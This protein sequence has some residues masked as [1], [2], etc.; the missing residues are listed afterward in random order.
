MTVNPAANIPSQSTST[1]TTAPFTYSPTGT[2][3]PSGTTYAWAAPTGANFTGGASGAALNA[4][5]TG[6]LTNTTAAAATAIYSVTPTTAGSTNC[7]GT[8]FTVSVVVNPVATILSQPDGTAIC[9][10]VA[11]SYTPTGTIPTTPTTTYAWSAP[12][13]ASG[14]SGGASGT[15]QSQLNGTLF[16]NST[17]SVAATA[18]Y[19]VTPT[20]GICTTG[21]VF[22]VTV[23]INPV[24]NIA[25][26]TTSKCTN[27]PFTYTPTG[28]IPASTTYAWAAPSVQAG[29]TGGVSGAAG[30]TT[31]TATLTNTTAGNL[32]AQYSVTPTSPGSCT[33]GAVFTVTVTV[34]PGTAPTIT[35]PTAI[36]VYGSPSNSTNGSVTG[37]YGAETFGAGSGSGSCGSTVAVDFNVGSVSAGNLKLWCRGDAGV[38][39]DG[40]SKVQAW[41]DV[42]GNGNNF[43]QPTAGSRPSYTASDAS[44][45]GNPAITIGTA[46][47]FL[48]NP[49]TLGNGTVTF[50]MF[51]VDRMNAGT[52]QRLVSSYNTNW[53][54]GNWGTYEDQFYFNSW[55]YGSGGTCGGTVTNTTPD[56]YPHLY[57]AT[58]NGV[59]ASGTNVY[60]MGRLLATCTA[61]T[62]NGPQQIQLGGYNSASTGSE[63]ST[64]EVAEIIYFNSILTTAQRQV[65]EGYL[66][67]KYNLPVPIASMQAFQ[68]YVVGSTNVSFNAADQQGNSTSANSTATVTQY[69]GPD[70][71]NVVNPTTCP[72][73][74][75][76]TLSIANM[77]APAGN[78]L[79]EGVSSSNMLSVSTLQSSTLPT[80]GTTSS[81][82][83]LGSNWTIETWV[84]FPLPANGAGGWNTLC[85][86]VGNHPIICQ[87]VNNTNA[88]NS[89]VILGCFN[90]GFYPASNVGA[91]NAYSIG[92]ASASIYSGVDLSNLTAGWH[93]VAAVGTGGIEKFY[94]DGIFV[95]K[96]TGGQV[97]DNLVAIGNYQGGGQDGGTLDEFKVY[98]TALSQQ[99]ISNYMT[100]PSMPLT[101]SNPDPN[102]NNLVAYYKMAANP[103]VNSAATILPASTAACTGCNG[104]LTGTA[105]LTATN[106][107]TYTWSGPNSPTFSPSSSST[108]ETVTITNP[109]TV[110]SGTYSVVAS[111]N[112]CSSQAT[113]VS[114]TVYPISVLT[115]VQGT[116]TC[117]NVAFSYTPTGTVIS[118]TTYAWSVPTGTGIGNGASG[119]GASIITGNLSSSLS[120]AATAT[121]LVTPTSPSGGT[122]T[123]CTDVV[124]TVTVVV[125]PAAIISSQAASPA[126]CS[127]VAFSYTPTGTIATGTTYSWSVPTQV[128]ITG[129][130][131]GAAGQTQLFGTLTNT[132]TAVQ[133]ATYSITPSSAGC[134]GTV[135]TESV[136]VNPAGIIPD[137][138]TTNCSN[139]TFS[140]T[141]TGTISAGTTYS[142]GIPTQASGLSGGSARVNQSTVNGNLVNNTNGTLTAVYSVTPVATASPGAC[143]G[144]TFNFTVSVSPTPITFGQST[145]T[146]S[147]STFSY[148]PSG[149]FIPNNTV[150]AWSSPSLQSGLSGGASGTGQATVNGTLTN[151]TTSALT[152]QYTVT[153]TAGSCT[154]FTF[155]VTVTVNPSQLVTLTSAAGTDNQATFCQG[156]PLPINIVY[157]MSGSAT[158]VTISGLPTGI[159]YTTSGSVVTISGTPSQAGTFNYTV[160]THGTCNPGTASGVITVG[161]A[162]SISN[163]SDTVC[164]DVAFSYTPTGSIPS[165][166]TYS[167][168]SPIM[169]AG[170]GGGTSGTSQST[171]HG[172]LTNTSAIPATAVYTVTFSST[173]TGASTTFVLFV[174]VN[175]DAVIPSQGTSSCTTIPFSYT[176]TGIVPTGTTYAWSAPSMQSGV[177]G[178]VSGAAGQT[179]LFGTLTNTTSAPATATYSV[180]PV[181]PPG[182]CTGAIFTVTVTVNPV[183]VISSQATSTC[184]G[185][186]FSYPPVGAIPVGTTYAWAAPSGVGV[187]GGGSGAGLSSLL[188]TLNN[189][190]SIPLSVTYSVTPTS[191]T[192]TT[193]APF[194]VTMT[195]NPKPTISSQTGTTC[196]AITFSYTPTGGTIPV[197]TTYQWGAPT[198]A[199]GVTG[200]SAG[201]PASTVTDVLSNTTASPLTATYVVTP[202]SSYGCTGAAFT[203]TMTVN[204]VPLT[205]RVDSTV[206]ACNGGYQSTITITGGTS[207][208]SFNITCTGNGGYSNNYTG[209]VPVSFDI[210]SSTTCTIGTVMDANTCPPISVSPTVA[211]YPDRALTTG[212]T[213]T[214]TVLSLQTKDFFDANA[215]L[216]ATITA[217]ATSLG[218]TTVVAMVDANSATDTT[219]THA[220]LPYYPDS[221]IHS[222][223]YLRRHF[224]ITPATQAPADI[225]LYISQAEVNDLFTRSGAH[226]L[227]TRPAFYQTFAIDASNAEVTQYEPGTG[228]GTQMTPGNHAPNP[229]TYTT[230]TGLTISPNPTVHGKIYSGDYSLCFTVNNFSGLYIHAANV[231]NDPLPVTLLTFTAVAVDN[232]FIK[233]DWSTATET[234]NSGFEVERSVDGVNFADMEW[235]PGHGNS[236]TPNNYEYNDLTALPGIVYYYRVRQVDIDGNFAY[237]NIASATLTGEN[238]F[239]LENIYPNPANSQVTVGVISNINAATTM[240]MTDM[241]G[242]VVMTEEW[243]MSIGYNI[244]QFDVSRFADGAYTVTVTSGNVTTSKK[245]VITK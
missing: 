14:L 191:G 49:A 81:T 4:T 233:T 140:Y 54:F 75:G 133:T 203:L 136:T 64:G 22:T 186:A 202:T 30:N 187:T 145:S 172:T 137:Q 234:N 156:T 143:T 83:T 158:S 95:G 148:A 94:I 141:P 68:N 107:Y 76:T 244:N 239:T 185:I 225:C 118:G 112:G 80:P 122:P 129:G 219:A 113:T 56:V 146:C 57:E 32:T 124:F 212:N 44:F 88:A 51:A 45:N 229:T 21:T 190:S 66:G 109:Q 181:S 19:S 211:T 180:T 126:T 73:V 174:N 9:S 7:T 208:Y 20:S 104:Y 175:P 97:T 169:G 82:V 217:H 135:F 77:I 201:G 3:L 116:T 147:G 26:Q 6:T 101:A 98:N 222:Q 152:A 173:C 165:G 139:I 155:V 16:N 218:S 193:G 205:A 40:S 188:G 123:T 115:P 78:C 134:I 206:D 163:Q 37:C 228:T 236:V 149:G 162:P 230:V 159:G 192:C 67:Y 84:K 86:T 39:L 63:F 138:G 24:A 182:T 111:A 85:R 52:N 36:T 164:A 183:A 2:I 237:S 43:I 5:L 1:C 92:S 48:Y 117:S 121:Y 60:D 200:G 227:H 221:S 103:V 196:S 170:L 176:P 23:T 99:A 89:G 168:S 50:T 46:G 70:S 130:A 53:L 34:T 114:V 65:V 29:V 238:G 204:E 120:V 42:S 209:P 41:Y 8:V 33:N 241:L 240:T 178:G 31:I 105:S 27:L 171:I 245:L 215:N 93:H 47:Q 72:N 213:Q 71:I 243:P 79:V 154:G 224:T 108:A 35:P 58:S 199:S 125:S 59:T 25:S 110:N 214:C 127:T 184:T 235:V 17:L 100:Q 18:T 150:Y 195:V 179:Q 166:T 216:M 153:P 220:N 223:S 189:N 198:R 167:W 96:T 69:P 242:R 62:P 177:T 131:S 210:Q 91:L 160:T 13:L 55:M 207:P 197:G 87:R 90:G 144:N 161:V 106:M 231:S 102:W 11:F 119:T 61:G 28:V 74:S 38:T 151:T 10:G 128:G 132:T 226:D 157:T 194:T 12:T 232:K 15:A 142:W